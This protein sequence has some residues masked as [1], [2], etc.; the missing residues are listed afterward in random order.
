VGRFKLGKGSCFDIEG[1]EG[2]RE[3][4]RKEQKKEKKEEQVT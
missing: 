1:G 3:G 4:G 2:G